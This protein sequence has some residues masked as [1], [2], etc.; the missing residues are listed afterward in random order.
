MDRPVVVVFAD[1]NPLSVSLVETLL[2]NLCQ[3]KVISDDKNG[4]RTSTRHL[5]KKRPLEFS[6]NKGLSFDYSIFISTR[7]NKKPDETG[8]EK[9]KQRINLAVNLAKENR[10]KCLLV[11]PYIQNPR[12][13]NSQV[14]A[15]EVF[16]ER[17]GE[18]GIVYIGELF[19][20]RMFLDERDGVAQS[21]K[22]FILRK[23]V[24]VTEG[25]V[26]FFPTYIPDVS[27][28]LVK[29]LFSFGSIGEE[30]ALFS[31]KTSF[32][33]F[34]DLLR[35]INP[36]ITFAQQSQKLIKRYKTD[37]RVSL[38]TNL[39]KAIRETLDWFIRY[40]PEEPK[41][42][43]E[44]KKRKTRQ[45]IDKPLWRTWKWGIVAVLVFV[46]SPFIFLLLSA[47][48]FYLGIR[49]ASSGNLPVAEKSMLFSQKASSFAYKTGLVFT[50]FNQTALV[51]ESAS[52]VSLR[53]LK[54]ADLSR[55]FVGN[56]LTET[57]YDPSVY[58]KKIALELDVL[59]KESGFLQ[60]E[61]S[62]S[63]G[64][65]AKNLAGLFDN[66]GLGEF[67]EKLLLARQIVEEMPEILGA[68]EKKEYLVVFQNNMELRPTGGFIGS[69]ALLTFEKG[70]L[71]DFRVQDVYS[72]DGQLKG[73]VEP[74][75]AIK[76]YLGE[77]NWFLRD[78][79]WDPD[80]PTSATR[81]EWFLEKE[82]DQS[83]DGVIG[84][85]LMLVSKLLKEV[86]PIYL[87]DF[88]QELN[89][90]NLY[91]V[92][93][94]EVEKDFFPG[95]YK[96]TNFLAALAQ[97]LLSQLTEAEPGNYLALSKVFYQSLEEKHVQVFFHN[98]EAQKAISG[99]GWEGAVYQPK[100]RDNCFA[101]WLGMVEANVG[102]NKANYFIERNA[103]L[104]VK[105]ED[106]LIK[107]Q[108][109]VFLKNK[110]NP[111]LGASGRYKTYL[112]ILAPQAARFQ[113]IEVISAGN[114]GRLVPEIDEISGR[115][116][117]GTVIE[118]GPGQTKS[119][120]F[121]WENGFGPDFSLPGEY[122]LFWRK[123][124]GT[125][126]DPIVVKYFFPRGVGVVGSPN[127][128]LTQEGTVG[129]NTNLARDFT[130]RV[131]W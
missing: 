127:F 26:H 109:T 43:I 116:E 20:P 108:L 39:E 97:E 14:F 115:K 52:G 5:G 123:Q 118:V 106:G 49:L 62:E 93:Q 71:S 40:K 24:R 91:E 90:Q 131:F 105:F 61:I 120:T 113:E 65:L 92:T 44:P 23:Q 110:A 36:Q 60:S 72:A 50:P 28:A 86:G 37:R 7:F 66:L 8:G 70:N 42:S 31:E 102:V 74:P 121:F 4:W 130:S 128:T 125:N 98:R 22:D 75:A 59:Y 46:L 12:F 111:A 107:K 95:S 85:D 1:P 68:E 104:S 45:K 82:I 17:D 79:N 34:S 69:F 35:K 76:D 99:L 101:D 11:F 18:T 58:S 119:I 27:K 56:I 55:Q 81:A 53:A 16:K 84:T 73:H 122:R 63:E 129:Y 89:S 41:V 100:C 103:D 87:S 78:S 29:S 19:G 48:S 25:S 10:A 80:F 67:R 13:R 54:V 30:I 94:Q 124:A 57:T 6:G 112:R 33:S 51:L 83:V 88:E 2:A 32:K 21:L 47:S 9:E 3:V 114:R 38:P 64:F 15:K 117:A 77:A 126:S 96:K